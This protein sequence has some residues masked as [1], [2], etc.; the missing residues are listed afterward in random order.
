ML[1]NA[2]KKA[3]T[4]KRSSGRATNV[5]D[6]SAFKCAVVVVVQLRSLDV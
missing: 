5:Q 4:E 1:A 6:R 3:G 2:E